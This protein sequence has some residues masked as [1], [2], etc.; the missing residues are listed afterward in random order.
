[1]TMITKIE[2]TRDGRIFLARELTEF[3]PGALLPP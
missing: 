1:M 2:A 3:L